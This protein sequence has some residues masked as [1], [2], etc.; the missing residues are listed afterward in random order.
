MKK[1]LPV[2][3]VTAYSFVGNLGCIRFPVPIR[4]VSG[5]KRGDRLAVRV[6]DANSVV[7][8]KLDI[9]NWIQTEELEVKPCNCSQPPES[10]NKLT[11][12][13]VTVGWSYVQ[14][15]E[16]LAIKLGFLPDTPVRM[17]GE[18][19]KVTVSPQQ[20]LKALEGVEKMACPP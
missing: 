16:E 10:C 12:G 5:I 8:E 6:G 15:K 1:S 9:P 14:L 2:A 13:L 20:D 3:P 7:L 4:K 17:V 11:P 19:S 18:L